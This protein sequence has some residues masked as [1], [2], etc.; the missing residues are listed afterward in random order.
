MNESKFKQSI[1]ALVKKHSAVYVWSIADKFTTGIPDCYYSGVKDLWV[2]FKF[3]DKSY[4]LT[5]LQKEW[6]I[7]QHNRGRNTAVI[8]GYKDYANLYTVDSENKLSIAYTFNSRLDTAK[9]IINQC[10]TL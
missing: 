10:Q 6:V 2:E 4:G 3:G 8:H 1:N 9:W 7:A 5:P